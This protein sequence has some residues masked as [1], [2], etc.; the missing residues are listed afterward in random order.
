M[1]EDDQAGGT[2]PEA[3]APAGPGAVAAEGPAAAATAGEPSGLSRFQASGRAVLAGVRVSS[4]L[5]SLRDLLGSEAYVDWRSLKT[6][7][8]LGQGAFATVSQ[9]S[10]TTPAGAQQVVA[11]KQIRCAGRQHWPD[12]CTSCMRSIEAHKGGRGRWS[13]CRKPTSVGARPLLSFPLRCR[14]ELLADPREVQLF[15]DEVKL[16]R[17]LR[18]K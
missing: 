18:H 8:P 2:E 14:T 9:V 12:R 4:R 17:K 6:L 3:E 1:G 13:A 5:H 10:F 11:K 7:R 16:L 15:V